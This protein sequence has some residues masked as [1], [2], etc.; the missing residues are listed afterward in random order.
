MALVLSLTEQ[1]QVF[2]DDVPIT[3][4]A[5]YGDGRCDLLVEGEVLEIMDTHSTEVLPNVMISAGLLAPNTKQIRLIFNA[6]RV[7]EIWRA[8]EYWERK[9]VNK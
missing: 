9:N 4:K 8:K 7:I 5:I 1:D 3:L 6:P 2:V